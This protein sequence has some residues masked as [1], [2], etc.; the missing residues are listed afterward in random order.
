[1]SEPLMELMVRLQNAGLCAE[2][3]EKFANSARAC[4]AEFSS[5]TAQSLLA[6]L[7]PRSERPSRPGPQKDGRPLTL[8]LTGPT[9]VGK[10]TTIAKLAAT[11]KLRLGM[12]VGLVTA[13]TYRIAAIEQ[14]RTYA[15]IIGLP[16][17]VAMTPPELQAAV[18][19]FDAVDVILVDTAGRSQRDQSRLEELRQ[20]IAAAAPHE[21]HLVVSAALSEGVLHCAVEKFRSLS[22]N[23]IIVTKMDEGVELGAVMNVLVRAG[24]PMSYL[25]TGQEVPDDIEP[26][27]GLLFARAILSSLTRSEGEAG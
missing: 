18:D 15:N 27:D 14:L 5:E 19:A 8:A 21:T 4:T 6:Q 17:K 2:L 12:R 25:T 23:R 11:Y 26:A 9:G 13:D 1:V 24:L 20:L 7:L 10:T 16:V 3:I 22:P